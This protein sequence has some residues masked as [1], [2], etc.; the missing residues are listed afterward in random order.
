MIVLEH[1]GAGRLELAGRYELES[2]PTQSH[3]NDQQKSTNNKQ[4][5]SDSRSTTLSESTTTQAN[6]IKTKE[7]DIKH[8][9]GS[10]R[11]HKRLRVLPRRMVR[12]A[13]IRMSYDDKR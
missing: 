2:V 4:N 13:K 10:Y 12:E 11:Y 5:N 6:S 3:G 8:S 9:P 7:K 1:D